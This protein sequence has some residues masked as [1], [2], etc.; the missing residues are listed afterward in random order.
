MNAKATDAKIVTT[1]KTAVPE[2]TQSSALPATGKGAAAACVASSKT[3]A[4]SKTFARKSEE[5]SRVATV[6]SSDESVTEKD[7]P[8]AR[9]NR[10]S[11]NNRKDDKVMTGSPVTSSSSKVA[12]GIPTFVS[13][14]CDSAASVA[15]RVCN[16]MPPVVTRML[17]MSNASTS[18]NTLPQKLHA[19]VGQQQQQQ[20]QQVSQQSARALSRN[21]PP[22]VQ[23]AALPATTHSLVR[24]SPGSAIA[25]AMAKRR[26]M[27]AL[28]HQQQLQQQLQLIQQHQLLSIQAAAAARWNTDVLSPSPPR[29]PAMTPSASSPTSAHSNTLA[30]VAVQ[31]GGESCSIRDPR[32]VSGISPPNKKQEGSGQQPPTKQQKHGMYKKLAEA[33][34]SKKKISDIANTLH[35][36]ISQSSGSSPKADLAADAKRPPNA[37]SASKAKAPE[38][39]AGGQQAHAHSK[40]SFTASSASG[41]REDEPLNLVTRDKDSHRHSNRGASPRVQTTTAV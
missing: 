31:S 32:E 9:G 20:Q 17:R 13:T 11:E 10:G 37:H 3:A 24:T 25:V 4:C 39:A 2:V 19:K 36:K 15:G 21:T 38:A 5:M 40:A 14:N 26:E 30:V 6:S 27:E 18:V 16:G 23:P 8:A 22:V 28:H 34:P 33:S 1:P 29:V 7:R 12:V 35:K 41:D